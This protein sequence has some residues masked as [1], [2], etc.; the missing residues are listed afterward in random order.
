MAYPL[1]NLLGARLLESIDD[2]DFEVQ[3]LCDMITIYKELGEEA[4]ALYVHY[5]CHSEDAQG[6]RKA[7]PRE[8][9]AS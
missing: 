7:Y 1:P 5:F 6:S 9:P 8:T 4:L 2:P 3:S